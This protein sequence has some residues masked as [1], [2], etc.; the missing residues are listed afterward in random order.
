M[1]TPRNIGVL[2][3]IQCIIGNQRQIASHLSYM[4]NLKRKKKISLTYIEQ[5]GIC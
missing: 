2:N 4:W 5:I 1:T 3:G